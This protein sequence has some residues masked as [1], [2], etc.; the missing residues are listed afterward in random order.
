MNGHKNPN[1]SHDYRGEIVITTDVSGIL[2]T[3]HSCTCEQYTVPI[4]PRALWQ[5]TPLEAIWIR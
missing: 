2:V 5:Q 4:L 3:M 1:D